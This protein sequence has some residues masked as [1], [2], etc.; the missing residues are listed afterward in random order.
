MDRQRFFVGV[1]TQKS[2]TSWIS[3][4]LA[5]HPEIGFSPIKEVH[6]FDSIHSE[7]NRDALRDR[8]RLRRHLHS[9]WAAKGFGPADRARLALRYMGVLRYRPD[10]YRAF[11]ALAARGRLGGEFT[12]G[13]A[14]LPEAGFAAIEATL[15]RPRYLAVFRNPA[16]RF[17]SQVGHN[18]PGGTPDPAV[19]PLALL[20]APD[21]AV[22]SDYAGFLDRLGRVVEPE[23][24][25]VMFF[26]HLFDPARHDAECARLCAFL[27]VARA[28]SVMA[29]R[30]N[31][32]RAPRSVAWDR[33]AVVARLRPQYE[34]FAARFGAQ[35]PQGWLRDLAGA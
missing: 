11:M 17:W 8:G 10:S 27:G 26:E 12:P 1:D 14:T 19:D 5:G 29:R 3:D 13:Y 23:R 15:S 21:Y 9:L 7:V 30:V 28:P 22:R 35:L 18:A 32:A 25:H 33:P 34:A 6:F 2:G 20:D 4:Y 24:I 16:D 31:E